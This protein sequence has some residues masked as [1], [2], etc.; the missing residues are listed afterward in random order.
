MIHLI[1]N[2][3]KLLVVLLIYINRPKFLIPVYTKVLFVLI[4]FARNKT[5]GHVLNFATLKVPIIKL[6]LFAALLKE[7][8]FLFISRS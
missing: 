3:N 7:F 1:L 4:N 2:A 6:I 5:T 8:H